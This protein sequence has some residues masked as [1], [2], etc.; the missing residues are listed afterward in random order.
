MS[1]PTLVASILCEDILPSTLIDGRI[2]LY[3]ILFDL[4]AGRFPAR[5]YRLFA[6]NLWRGGHGEDN[7]RVQ[8]VTPPGQIAAQ[9]ESAFHARLQGHHAQIVRFDDLVLPEP[10]EYAVITA[11]NGQIVQTY[12]IV[13]ADAGQT[14]TEED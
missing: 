4:T 10:G 2:T 6:V 12:T 14:K 3:R 1:E 7:G 9:A 13:V 5:A 11:R 8:I